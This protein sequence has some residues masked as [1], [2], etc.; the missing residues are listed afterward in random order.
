MIV[1]IHPDPSGDESYATK[2]EQFLRQQ[3]VEVRW[4][5]LLRADAIEQVRDL[6]GVM[7]RWAHNQQHKQSARIVLYTI[8][9]VLGIPVYPDS[10]TCWHYDDKISQYYLFKSLGTPIPDTWIFWNEYDAT[11]WARQAH[12]PIV[13]KLTAGAGSANVLKLEKF[14][15]AESIIHKMFSGG[16]YPYTFNEFA[17]NQ[18][19]PNPP[20]WKPEIDYFYAQEFLPGNEYDT[21]VMII[22]KRAFA[23]RRF[24]RPGDFR[25]SGSERRDLDPQNVDLRAVKIAFETSQR[26]GFS[27]MAYDFL[28]KAGQPVICE[29]SYT[30][31]HCPTC[32]LS[33][34]W[35]PDLSW[36]SGA[37][38][39]E[40]A[41]VEDFV[42]K[43]KLRAS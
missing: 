17:V 18:P 1:G 32:N 10:A 5:D 35:L 7:W 41:Q 43:I 22:G 24:N 38:W 15:Q 34:H 40:E 33:G 13:F 2:W 6:D 9:H 27:C 19:G 26:G 8:E 29:I 4:L 30:F 37:M 20:Y 14:T 42:R 36:A 21:R 12:Y 25:A 31:P 16:I 28:Y 23:F 11:Q 3:G 39:P